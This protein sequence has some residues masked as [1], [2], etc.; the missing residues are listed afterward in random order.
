MGMNHSDKHTSKGQRTALGQAFQE[1]PGMK[2]VGKL[3]RM[4]Q[5]NK[6]REKGKPNA[7]GVDR[8][9]ARR[10]TPDSP[11][12][13]V[14]GKIGSHVGESL[15]DAAEELPD[16]LGGNLVRGAK[17]PFGTER[18]KDKQV[19]QAAQR[20]DK[21]NKATQELSDRVNRVMGENE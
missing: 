8:Q 1:T 7:T 9:R 20:V 18:W 3:G 11:L 14:L 5:R 12:R 15:R 19:R 21:R 10:D 16:Y 6:D 13:D 17:S 2:A 4:L